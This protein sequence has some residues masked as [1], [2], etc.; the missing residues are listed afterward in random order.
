MNLPR[1][2]H[3]IC[4][5]RTVCVIQKLKIQNGTIAGIKTVK[6][7]LPATLVLEAMGKENVCMVKRR[8]VILRQLLETDNV[9]I[10]RSIGLPAQGIHQ[11]T[12]HP[13]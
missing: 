2:S 12:A 8:I 6:Q 4:V 11:W 5:P 1:V 10:G 7:F 13:M 9:G 3:T